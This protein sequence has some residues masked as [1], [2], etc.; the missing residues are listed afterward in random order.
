MRLDF[1]SSVR[2]SDAAFGELVDVVV[3]PISRRVTHVVVAPHRHREQARLVAIERVRPADD[4]LALDHSI[5]DVE[6]LESL[7]ETAYVRTGEQ[8]VADPDWDVGTEDVLAMPLYQEMDG[9]GTVV[10]LDPHVL[11]SYDRIPKSEVEIR[12]SS[13]VISTD[14]HHLGHVEGFLIGSG[15]TADILLERGHLWGR[16]E[17][18]I[19]ASAVERVQ[20]DSI[21]LSLTKEE[22]AALDVRHVH[23]WF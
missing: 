10:D 3:D 13:A 6:A 7:R 2:C 18:V 4:G 17:V 21:T 19:P 1:G 23:R 11:L 15:D 5:A 22:V 20:N 14:G 16:R 9:M 8:V 12:R